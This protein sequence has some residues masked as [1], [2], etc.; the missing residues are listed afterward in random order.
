MV[1]QSAP[2][3]MNKVLNAADP[4]HIIANSGFPFTVQ[5]GMPFNSPFTAQCSSPY[6]VTCNARSFASVMYL[7]YRINGLNNISLR[8]EFFNDMEGQRTG[9]KTRYLEAGIG[10]QHWLSPQIEFRPEVTWYHSMDANAF[11]GNANALATN[12]S[13]TVILPT[14]NYSVVAAMDLIWHF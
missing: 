10:W 9:V 11:N 4:D 7:N 3:G 8:G 6:V 12:G 1:A 13:G 14:R 2:L 5:N